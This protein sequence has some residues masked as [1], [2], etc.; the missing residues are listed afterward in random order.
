MCVRNKHVCAISMCAQVAFIVTGC[1][2]T[3]YQKTLQL[4]LGIKA[5]SMPIFFQ[6]IESMYPMVKRML[7][8][9]CEI[10]NDGMK[11]MNQDELDS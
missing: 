2:H 3:V 4:A 8:K 10:A 7:D 9:V 1:T 5:V 6:T 11:E